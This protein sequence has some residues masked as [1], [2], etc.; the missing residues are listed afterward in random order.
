MSKIPPQLSGLFRKLSHLAA[1]LTKMSGKIVY[2]VFHTLP[3]FSFITDVW[4]PATAFLCL[5]C[6]S[7]WL[8]EMLFIELGKN[9]VLQSKH[10]L[11][12]KSALL[13]VVA[14]QMKGAVDQHIAQLLI[15]A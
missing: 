2:F 13:V 11:S 8:R 1:K 7:C 5:T 12:F 6:W 3:F 9:L 4:A 10:L 15:F 14:Q